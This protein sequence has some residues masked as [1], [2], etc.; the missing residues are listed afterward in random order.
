[1]IGAAA[2]LLSN[3]L[4]NISQSKSFFAGA[5]KAALW[6]GVSAAAGLGIGEIFRGVGGAARNC[7]VPDHMQ[8]RSAASLLREVVV[9]DR[10]LSVE[11]SVRV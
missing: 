7:Y 4:S 10:V 3:G 5:G 2:D 8:L 1:L 6:G 9:S 11:V